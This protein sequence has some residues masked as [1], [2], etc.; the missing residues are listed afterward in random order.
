MIK[1][2]EGRPWAE[3]PKRLISI[4]IKNRPDETETHPHV[5]APCQKKIAMLKL[6]GKTGLGGRYADLRV[7]V[8][9]LR[10]DL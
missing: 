10:Q 6:S 1:V 8:W 3:G 4:S 5:R 2:G 7:Q 9:E